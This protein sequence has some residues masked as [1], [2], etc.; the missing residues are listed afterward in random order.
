MYKSNIKTIPNDSID[1]SGLDSELQCYSFAKRAKHEVLKAQKIAEQSYRSPSEW[2]KCL[3]MNAYSLWFT[4]FPAF[5]Y[6]LNQQ[7]GRTS[8]PLSIAYQ[9]LKRMQTMDFS[10]PDEFCY[11]ILMILCSIHSRPAL[12]VKIF[13]DMKHFNV[14]LNAIT[15]GYYNKAVLDGDWPMECN[16][17]ARWIKLCNV[18]K[19]LIHFQKHIKSTNEIIVEKRSKFCFTEKP[20]NE[21]IVDYCTDAGILFNP[22]QMN[23]IPTIVNSN[24]LIKRKRN[25]SGNV[26]NKENQISKDELKKI[27]N[28]LLEWKNTHY[29]GNLNTDNLETDSNKEINSEKSVKNESEEDNVSEKNIFSNSFVTPI[30][31]SLDFSKSPVADKLRSSFRIAKNF[32]K[33]KY[34][35]LILFL[36]IKKITIFLN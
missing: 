15:Y 21:L 33:S 26:N 22:I 10:V 11:R 20:N 18:M 5:S 2:A 6:L 28:D 24:S 32:T 35:K 7:N 9:A 25:K 34:S 12:A 8:K 4:H 23:Y 17:K 36:L 31:A 14:K 3:L 29:F 16:S 27:A 19:V 30:K 13:L 1:S